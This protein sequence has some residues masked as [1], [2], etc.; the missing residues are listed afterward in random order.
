MLAL[1]PVWV[2]GDWK[3]GEITAVVL[4]ASEKGGGGEYKLDRLHIGHEM[5]KM[6]TVS[7][8]DLLG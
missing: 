4:G 2:N 3:V 6:L 5:S 7:Q 1:E 8:V